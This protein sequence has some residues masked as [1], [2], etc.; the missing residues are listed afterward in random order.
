[1][2]ARG[3]GDGR[4]V[5]ADVQA[6]HA[7]AKRLKLNLYIKAPDHMDSVGSLELMSGG[8]EAG[9]RPDDVPA[10]DVLDPRTVAPADHATSSSEAE[11]TGP[12]ADHTTRSAE[13]A[14]AGGDGGPLDD[15]LSASTL[16]VGSPLAEG[17]AGRKFA[18]TTAGSADDVDADGPTGTLCNT[19]LRSPGDQKAPAGG[20]CGAWTP[21]PHPPLWTPG[22]RQRGA[23]LATD[24]SLR[25]ATRRV[26]VV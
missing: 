8:G 21:P 24:L 5:D 26:G 19:G 3:D 4:D 20:L 25:V 23:G 16:L 11:A 1:M 17:A 9:S 13:T 6:P 2:S 18:D 10:S 22:P 15:D 12:L 7:A 14:G